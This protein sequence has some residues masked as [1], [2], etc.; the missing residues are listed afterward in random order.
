MHIQVQKYT[1]CLQKKVSLEGGGIVSQGFFF[2]TEECGVHY[3]VAPGL[4]LLALLSGSA[5]LHRSIAAYCGVW[6]RRQ[7]TQCHPHRQSHR[8]LGQEVQSPTA[9]GAVS[10]FH[11][12]FTA[13]HTLP[14][15]H[16]HTLIRAH[17]RRVCCIIKHL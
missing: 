9:H 3:S 12:S 17:R 1:F 4:S 2:A 16:T 14:R 6:S 15:R 8:V 7:V 13:S 10:S 5:G 11:C